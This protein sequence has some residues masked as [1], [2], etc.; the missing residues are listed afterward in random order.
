MTTERRARRWLQLDALYCVV[1]GVL[2]LTLAAPLGRLFHVAPELAAGAG[3]AAVVWGVLLARFA[4]RLTWRVPLA[5][6]AT[7]NAAASAA[8]VGLAIVAPGPA[9]HIVLAAVALE[10][11]A[12]ASIQLRILRHTA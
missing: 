12:F 8:L 10:V 4:T 1:A 6:V 11:A 3:A 2:T 7:A 9:A 5:L